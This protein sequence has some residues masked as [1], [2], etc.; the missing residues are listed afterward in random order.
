MQ[1]MKKIFIALAFLFIIFIGYSG[2]IYYLDNIKLPEMTPSTTVEKYFEAVKSEDYK[3]AYA[4]V[5]QQ[6]YHDSYNQF[7]DRM[8][9]YSTEMSVQITG[10]TINDTKASV[11]ARII[12]PMNF[13]PFTTES[14]I[15]LVRDKREWKILHP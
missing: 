4:F 11:T 3:N 13:G 12:V 15:D 14:V 7:V 8:K 2:Y 1:K 9:T 6:Y 5:S 10:E